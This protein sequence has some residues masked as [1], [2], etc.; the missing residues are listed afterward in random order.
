MYTLII[1][2]IALGGALLATVTSPHFWMIVNR[3]KKCKHCYGEGYVE[4]VGEGLYEKCE[5]C[6]TK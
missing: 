2:L 1:L 6:N 3:K 4:H 5:H